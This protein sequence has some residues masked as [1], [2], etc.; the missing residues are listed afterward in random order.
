MAMS[1]SSHLFAD[2]LT[3]DT[4]CNFPF[5]CECLSLHGYLDLNQD[6]AF[7]PPPVPVLASWGTAQDQFSCNW[8]LH[9][10][11]V[12]KLFS[13]SG[14]LRLVSRTILKQ[15]QLKLQYLFKPSL[16]RDS[17]D[18]ASYKCS[19]W[20]N[21]DFLHTKHLIRAFMKPS[22]SFIPSTFLKNIPFDMP[23]WLIMTGNPPT[24]LEVGH[25]FS[26]FAAS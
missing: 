14:Y 1:N 9:L 16:V 15:F 24:V 21:L 17:L 23:S 18:M 7:E 6:L 3:D 4:L 19:Y 10:R 12:H 8:I 2:S 22:E 26:S 11:C 13:A 20:C 25:F 5:L